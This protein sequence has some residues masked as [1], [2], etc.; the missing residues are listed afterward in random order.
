M[1]N[2]FKNTFSFPLT[3]ALWKKFSHKGTELEKLLA[4]IG[5]KQQIFQYFDLYIYVF[6]NVSNVCKNDRNIFQK[7]GMALKLNFNVVFF[8]SDDFFQEIQ[9]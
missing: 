2:C 5:E 4:L 3:H 1:S 6:I 9:I 8:Y 7:K